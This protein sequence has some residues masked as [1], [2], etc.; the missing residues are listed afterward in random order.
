MTNNCLFLT[1]CGQNT[2]PVTCRCSS[3]PRTVGGLWGAPGQQASLRPA[4]LTPMATPTPS[5][6]ALSGISPDKASL[7]PLSLARAPTQLE[8]WQSFLTLGP[9][10]IE[11]T[12]MWLPMGELR[13]VVAWTGEDP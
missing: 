1:H 4:F 13:T 12:G 8:G 10:G 3:G 11:G 6:L 5:L 9:G 7:C 2:S